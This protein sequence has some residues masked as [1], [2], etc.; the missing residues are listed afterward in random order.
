MQPDL[1]TLPHWDVTNVYLSLESADFGAA[2]AELDARLAEHER[3]LDRDGIGGKGSRVEADPTKL[4]AVVA[5]YVERANWLSER[6]GTLDAYITAF[7]TTNT[8]DDL[9]RRRASEL[10]SRSVR[11]ES[12]EVRFMAW[13]RGLEGRV[14]YLAA[15]SPVIAAHRFAVEEAI[16]RARHLMTEAEE[17]LAND[18]SPAGASA[19]TRLHGVVTS[20]I[21]VPFERERG[22]VEKL[23]MSKLRA[24]SHDPDA[25]VRR[26][27]YDVELAA[28][29]QWQEPLAACLNGV[30]G[31]SA[32]LNE[33]R[34][35]GAAI[36]TSIETARIDRGTLDA[37]LDAMRGSLPDFRRYLKAK[38]R[39][40][41]KAS[42]KL[43]WHD[44]FAP[45]GRS[46]KTWRWDEAESFIV[47]RFGTF[48]DRLAA[49]ARKAFEGRWVD[50]EPRVGKV[51]GAFCMGVPE[52]KE[53]RILQNFDGTFDQVS[54]L[55]HELGHGYHNEVLKDETPH[56]RKTPMTLAE[57]ASIFCETIA[58]NAALAEAPDDAE[59]LA[60]VETNLIGACQVVVDIYSRYLFETR[61][62]ERRAESELA[63]ADFCELVAAAEREAYGDALDD[64]LHPYM[65]AVKPHYYSAGFS[66]YNYPYAFGLLFGLGLYAIYKKR[67]T[68]FVEDYDRL[69]GST[70]LGKA[71]ELCS[72]FGID[73]TK[74]A[75][76]E[77]GLDEVRGLIGTYEELV[78][79]VGE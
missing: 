48:S 37:L 54:T 77:A 7:T 33:R 47:S 75:F 5:G 9:A 2:R 16:E 79:K 35:Y 4:A 27:A 70:G 63:A 39:A 53:S 58:F 32:K 64:R 74:R 31:W 28:W 61:V 46:S 60:I 52:A 26:R 11:L 72:R 44:I 6:L 49:F 42:G 22:K 56:R 20:Q 17:V 43:S 14:D 29:K 12:A 40:L 10:E 55:A 69:L 34:G 23:P 76:W 38:A 15:R 24:L 1:G 73:I 36:D 25:D 78:G 51:G 19:R 66:F 68:A 59:R 3:A 62:F 18:L 57:T 30:K 21:E 13:S 65:W 45:V 41:G 8:F 67:G 71:A 50:A